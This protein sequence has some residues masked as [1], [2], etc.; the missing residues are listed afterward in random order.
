MK[1]ASGRVGHVCSSSMAVGCEPEESYSLARHRHGRGGGIG[2]GIG[3]APEGSAGHVT[4]YVDVDDP[5]AYLAKAE[6][7]GGKTVMPPTEVPGFG[8]TF[9][10]FSDPEGHVLGLTKA[11]GGQQ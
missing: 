11:G 7:L 2:G 5:A 1:L 8:V 10:L 4:V 6:Q 9:A 3:P